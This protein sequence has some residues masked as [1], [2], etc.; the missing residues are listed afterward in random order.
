V[1]SARLEARALDDQRL[2]PPQPLEDCDA[3]IVQSAL[4]GPAE[5]FAG[6]ERHPT[7]AGKAAVLAYRVVK[8]HPCA[9]GNKRLAL[10]LA[11]AFLE[12]NGCDLE[13]SGEEIEHIF[14]HVAASE[15]AAHT[16]VIADLTGW[17]DSATQ[18]L[19]G[20]G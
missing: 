5:G 11:S 18:P 3:P 13:A 20:E 17:F 10:I 19:T 6:V 9:D 4:A 12:A 8:G 16:A 15:S 1:H 14:R 7:L 2:A